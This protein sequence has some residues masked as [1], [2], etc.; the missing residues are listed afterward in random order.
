MGVPPGV[1]LRFLWVYLAII[2]PFSK[3]HSKLYH[4]YKMETCP[5]RGLKAWGFAPPSADGSPLSEG[6]D[7]LRFSSKLEIFLTFSGVILS[8]KKGKKTH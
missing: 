6:K 3:W 4:F 2:E 1:F 5:C 8:Y 7:L